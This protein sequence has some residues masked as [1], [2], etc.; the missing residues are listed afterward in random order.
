M[1]RQNLWTAAEISKLQKLVAANKSPK[2]INSAFD[3][4]SF[5]AIRHKIA[6]LKSGKAVVG[7][8]PNLPEI[9]FERLKKEPIK[10]LE[11]AREYNL[12]TR[13]V[14]NIIFDLSKSKNLTISNGIA[15]I[16]KPSFGQI[17]ISV[18]GDE[19]QKYGL[20]AD[21]HLGCKEERLDALHA[22]YDIYEQ[23]GIKHV[24]HAGNMV[25]GY[26]QKINNASAIVTTP[27]GQAQ[28]VIDNYPQ[29]E[30]ITTYF[31]TGDDHEGWWIKD[32]F[33]WGAYL[34]MM[35]K[36]QGRNDLVY[37][38]HV[39]A[40]VDLVTKGGK[41]VMK[42]Q[43]PGG[44]SSYA[45]SYTGQK[46]VE[47][48]QGGEKPQ[49]LVQ[50][51]YHVNNYMYERNVH[52]ISLPGF[53]DQ[54]VFARKKRLRMDVGGGMIHLKQNPDDGSIMRFKYEIIPFFDRKYYQTYLRSDKKLVH[55]NLV[56]NNG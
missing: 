19:W 12:T 55:G 29:R 39:E 21:T 11:F 54:T 36:K 37:L 10:V 4:R 52:V 5:S 38:G 44:G 1:S 23:E 26:I 16:V 27:D 34:E 35:A 53:Q 8:E 24:F 9:I 46:Q 30:G 20:V 51:H 15:S 43:H 3:N 42:V 25:D 41:A 6:E 7:H 2:D 33:N 40:D 13:Q 28:Y 22:V 48:F 45:R 32:G 56:I 49:I 14:E 47:A 31:I 50:G 17:D 18:F